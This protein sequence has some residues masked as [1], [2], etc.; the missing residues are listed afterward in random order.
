MTRRLCLRQI[1]QASG[2]LPVLMG[3]SLMLQ[4]LAVGVMSGDAGRGLTSL[5]L[6]GQIVQVDTGGPLGD[7]GGAA[8]DHCSLCGITLALVAMEPPLA[9]APARA[10]AQVHALPDPRPR[11][12]AR[13]PANPARAPP[14]PV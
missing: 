2:A 3:L 8:P 13:L 1:L 6:N 9:A 4:L 12:P 10:A 7:L 5:C 11:R 14:L